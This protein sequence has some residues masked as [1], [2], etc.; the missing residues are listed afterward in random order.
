MKNNLTYTVLDQLCL[1]QAGV[2]PDVID[3]AV[4]REIINAVVFRLWEKRK[5]NPFYRFTSTLAVAADAEAL[6][7]VG[8][9]IPASPIILAGSAVITDFTAT[10]ITRST[11][12]FPVGSILGLTLIRRAGANYGMGTAV[13]RVTL[14]GATA[15]FELLI[16]FMDAYNAANDALMVAVLKSQSVLSSDF[17]PYYFDRIIRIHDSVSRPTQGDFDAVGSGEEFSNL[18]YLKTKASRVA[19]RHRGTTIDFFVGSSA[20]PLGVIM[21]EYAGKPGTYTLA[22]ADT[23]IL[24]QPEDNA[25]LIAEVTKTFSEISK[26]PSVD[27][28]PNRGG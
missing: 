18:K 28:T 26:E 23:E 3:Q 9:T 4:R 25:E 8:W 6:C 14:G 20:L 19:Y 12:T 13:A 1:V 15:T 17:S 10:T 24:L 21:V 7:T 5:D 2:D 11:G 22:T 27:K 16:G